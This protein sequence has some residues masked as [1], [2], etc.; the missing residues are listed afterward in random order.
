MKFNEMYNFF[1]QLRIWVLT[2][3]LAWLLFF[4]VKCWSHVFDCEGPSGEAMQLEREYWNREN[5][6]A[7][8]RCQERDRE[9]QGKDRSNNDDS[10]DRERANTYLNENIACK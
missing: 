9:N 2:L 4:T 7:Y 8:E 10:R 1:F 5:E 6:K 3:M